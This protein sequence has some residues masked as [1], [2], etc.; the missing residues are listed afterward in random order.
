M[1]NLGMGDTKYYFNEKTIKDYVPSKGVGNYAL[2]DKN[3]ESGQFRPKYVG[4]SDTNLQQELI[5]RLQEKGHH[6]LF[7]FKIASNISEAFD[8]ECRNYHDFES[9]LENEIHPASPAGMNLRCHV[10]GK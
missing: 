5:A 3:P 8:T 9:H 10:C 4:R 6:K 2:G 7:K 1:A